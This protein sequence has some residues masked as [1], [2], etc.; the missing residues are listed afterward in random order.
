MFQPAVLVP[1]DL[2]QQHNTDFTRQA[3]RVGLRPD[4]RDADQVRP[5]SIEF[6]RGP[7][8]RRI[9]GAEGTG[10]GRNDDDASVDVSTLAHRQN[11]TRVQLKLGATHVSASIHC[12]LVEPLPHQPKHGFF[13]VQVKHLTHERTVATSSA[14]GGAA[15]GDINPNP[16]LF[17]S[18]SAQLRQF[19]MK[20]FKG[21]VIDTEGLCVVPGQHVWSL[22]VNCT[23]LH[24]DGN[25][26]DACQ[27]AVLALLLAHRRPEAVILPPAQREAG[28][29]GVRLYEEWERDPAPLS[30]LH[31]PLSCSFAVTEDP[32]QRLLEERQRQHGGGAA[33]TSSTPT[34]RAFEIVADPTL[35]EAAA[36]ASSIT[37]VVN[38]EG[39]VCALEKGGGPS[40]SL[41]HI[42]EC[43]RLAG[44]AGGERS[45][46]E[47]IETT[48]EE[49][50]ASPNSTA[51]FDRSIAGYWWSVID[52]AV[53]KL[54]VDRQTAR[55]T[56]F[57]WAKQRTGVSAAP[58]ST[59]SASEPSAQKRKVE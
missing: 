29:E 19:L 42:T 18:S 49:D 15:G 53:R 44:G 25:A 30:L 11:S 1:A 7:L 39:Q 45:D 22:T 41:Q 57:Q 4:Q 3:W 36:A 37:V 32:H 2:L 21:G 12:H 24:N 43:L 23:L 55:Q 27:L 13:E 28:G 6:A 59:A 17:P 35:E 46:N 40:V 9:I 34:T 48:N 10:S 56:Q 5:L 26:V 31:T 38:R 47:L 50:G 33:G 52:K 16:D 51:A 58:A 14:G 8:V 20:L 54:E